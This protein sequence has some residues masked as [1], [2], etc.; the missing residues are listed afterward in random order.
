MRTIRVWAAVVAMG[1]STASQ[2]AL[3]VNGDFQSGDFTG[4]TL[5][6]N[7]GGSLGTD[8]YPGDLGNPTFPRPPKPATPSVQPFDTDG[9]G[10]TSLAAAFDAG[11]DAWPATEG[12]G[13]LIQVLST[14]A[15]TLDIA[16]AVAAWVPLFTN[17]DAG[18]ITLSVDGVE[19]DRH[20]FGEVD[21]GFPGSTAGAVVRAALSGSAGVGAGAHELRIGVLRGYGNSTDTPL[22]YIDDVT[23]AFTPV[24][25]PAAALL[26]GGALPLL[27]RRRR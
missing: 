20:A 11:I 8:A 15:G 27:G 23:V 12:G 24:P 26:L 25:I 6:T 21:T 4:W 16:F 9:D 22:Q 14:G 5:F 13:G 10:T 18:T 17:G 2:G 7:P 3:L 19:L 1:M